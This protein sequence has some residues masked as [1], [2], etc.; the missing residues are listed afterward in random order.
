MHRSTVFLLAGSV[1]FGTFVVVFSDHWFSVWVGLEIN[2]LGI[3]PIL[4]YQFS[5]RSVESTVKYFVVQSISAA[6]ILNVG[7]TQSLFFN[8][9]LLGQPLGWFSSGVL[10]LAMA[11][12][13]GLFPCHFWLPDVL[14]GVGFMQGLVLS[15]WQKIAPFLVLIYVVESLNV[16][17]FCLVG[18]FSSLV[19][20]W[21]GLNQTQIRKILA[22]S[23]ISHLGWICS[24]VCYSWKLGLLM[25]FVYVFINSGV[26]LLSWELNLS[27][28]GFLGRMFFLNYVSGLCFF[29]VVLSLGGLPPLFGFSIKFLAL[30]C[31][32]SNGGFLVGGLLIFGSL[33]SLF[34]YLRMAVSSSLS[35]FPQHAFVF[36][37]WRSVLGAHSSFSFYGVLLGCFVVVSVFG[38]LGFSALVSFLN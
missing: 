23:S 13:L 15:T 38:M 8:S 28:L 17:L 14:Q 35:F 5:P 22:F 6:V 33:L 11:L 12:K 30:D 34:F 24:V 27:F 20:G 36:F 21:G 2:T 26:F 25:F 10:G 18:A 9:W 7:L 16:V 37:S 32:I 31:I 29:L 3:I 4:C 19:G 1:L